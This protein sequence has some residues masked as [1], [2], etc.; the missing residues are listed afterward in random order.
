DHRPEDAGALEPRIQVQAQFAR[1]RQV[2]PLP[3]ANDDSI[4]RT[5]HPRTICSFPYREAIVAPL[6]LFDPEA[7]DELQATAINEVPQI[8]SKPAARRQLVRRAA[9]E[10]TR[11]I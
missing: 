7:Q 2:G 4:H 6:D 3:G 5:E 8:V 9:T 10:N 1:Q 11:Q